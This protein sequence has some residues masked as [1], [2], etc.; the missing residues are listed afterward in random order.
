MATEFKKSDKLEHVC[1]DIRG[2]VME[3]AKRLEEAGFKIIKLNIGNPA[4]FGFDAP[5]EIIHDVMINLRN[6]QGYTDS[7]GLFAAR[8]AIMQYYQIKKI[9]DIKIDDIYIGNGVSELIVMAMQGLLN[10]G[11]EILIPAPDY[12]L[13]TAAVNLSGGTAVHYRCDESSDWV[14]DIEDIRRKVT[15]K[16]KGIV[17][18]NPNNPTGAVYPREILQ[19][20]IDIACEHNLIIFSDEIYDKVLYDD[21][22]HFPIASMTSDVLV[23]TLNGLS[24]SHRI[25]GFRAGWMVISGKKGVARDY[26]EGLNILSSMRLCS[27]VPAQFAIQTSLGGYQ[28]LTELLLPGGRLKRQRDCCYELI[29]QI[30]GLS[31]TK[32]MGAFYVFPKVDVKKFN[33]K[34]DLRFI[35]DLLRQKKVLLVQGTGFNWFEPDHFR[36]VFLPPVD[37]LTDAINKLGDFLS[38]YRQK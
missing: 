34:D 15:P 13:W 5:D 38:T 21:A 25:A 1:Y 33:I 28:S 8:K 30:P 22:Q 37:E 31:C 9:P 2:P 36:L 17:V 35:L 10:N 32:P 20:I 23:I 14:P 7:N 27:N 6:A 11:D 16:T 4:P 3:E 19:Q 12:P 26:I 18:I 29:N 24:K